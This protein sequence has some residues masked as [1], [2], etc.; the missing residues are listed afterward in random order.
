MNLFQL[1]EALIDFG[2]DW[3][4]DSLAMVAGGNLLRVLRQVGILTPKLSGKFTD[5]PPDGVS[6]NSRLR[7]LQTAVKE[8]LVTIPGLRRH[9]K[10]LADRNLVFNNLGL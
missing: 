2:T 5:M 8:M 3:D 1:F 9:S 6:T 4:D 10:A 7:L